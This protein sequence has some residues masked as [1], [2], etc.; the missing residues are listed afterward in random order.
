[1]STAYYF[2][3]LAAGIVSTVV[4][5]V[6]RVK[7][8]G[9][10]GLYSKAVAS[11]FFLLTALAA[12]NVN[13]GHGVFAGLIVFGLALGLSG[14]IWL[15]LKWIYEKDMGSFLNAG[16]I[17]FL[18]GHIFYISAVYSFCDNWTVLTALLPVAVSVVVSI[19][20]VIV[21]GKALGLKFGRFR[22]IVGIYT[23]FLFM[24]FTVSVAAML[25]TGFDK[26]WILMSVGGLLFVLSDAVLSTM[27]FKDGCNTKINIIINHALY[28]AAQFI[29]ASAVLVIK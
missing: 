25:L 21:I 16:F 5:I 1:M 27:Y 15:D 17:A 23:F 24:T 6:L 9:F 14:D 13:S 8:G 11:F 12:A 18:I 19:I 2:A 4:F 29:I 28:Y 26:E 22:T 3:A 20:N 7:Y 10:K